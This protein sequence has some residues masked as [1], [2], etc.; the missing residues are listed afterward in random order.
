MRARDLNG[1]TAATVRRARRRRRHPRADDRLRGGEPRAARRAGRGGGL[2][3]RRPRSTI[4]RPRTAACA[5]CSR[6]GSVARASRSAS[7]ARSRASRP[8]S[9]GRCPSSSAPIARGRATGW[10]CA[11]RS[12]STRG[13]GRGATT[14]SSRSCICRRRGW[15]RRPRRCG[16]FPASAGGADRRRAVVRLPDGRGRSADVRVCRGRG[17]RRRGSRELRRGGRCDRATADASPGMEVRDVLTG[18]HV[19]DHAH[20]SRSTR[21]ARGRRRSWRCSAMPRPVPLLKAMN[22]VTSKPA[23]DMALAAPTAT[24]GC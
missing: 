7:A 8:G 18:A 14:A 6:R 2:R 17:P 5:R 21:P 16:C 23:S 10:R 19:H 4:R 20:A 11:P 12:S 9:C 3:Q 24:A 15:C 13:S 22:L 1:S